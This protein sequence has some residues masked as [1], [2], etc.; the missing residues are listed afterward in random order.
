MLSEEQ[1]DT[2]DML[3]FELSVVAATT[4]EL[5]FSAFLPVFTLFP[6]QQFIVLINYNQNLIGARIYCVRDHFEVPSR[7]YC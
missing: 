1:N 5:K 7:M 3:Y 6:P 4:E 2:Y